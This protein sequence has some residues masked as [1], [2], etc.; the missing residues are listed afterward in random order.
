MG[1]FWQ[2]IRA[3]FHFK[4]VQILLAFDSW[5]E[6]VILLCFI[7]FALSKFMKI[8]NLHIQLEKIFFE[9]PRSFKFLNPRYHR[10]NPFC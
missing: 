4:F 1:A 8:V 2:H 9:D 3:Y 10:I 5:M 7:H 6:F